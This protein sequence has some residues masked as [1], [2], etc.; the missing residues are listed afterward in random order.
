MVTFDAK[1]KTAKFYINGE[2][3]TAA[4]D[5][6]ASAGTIV[7]DDTTKYIGWNGAHASGGQLTGMLD[8]V[9]LWTLP[10][11]LRPRSTR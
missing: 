2:A 11:W 1:T 10:R 9:N 3:Q 5:N 4:S 8:D 7:A 6:T